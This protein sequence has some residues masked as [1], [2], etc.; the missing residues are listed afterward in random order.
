MGFS[1]VHPQIKKAMISRYKYFISDN[2]DTINLIIL[3]FTISLYTTRVYNL[4]KHLSL[5]PQLPL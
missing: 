3:N 5:H 4:W 1:L 2:L